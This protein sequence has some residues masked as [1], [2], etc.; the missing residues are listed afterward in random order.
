[1]LTSDITRKWSESLGSTTR[2]LPMIPQVFPA[3]KSFV[4]ATLMSAEKLLVSV[5][6]KRASKCCVCLCSCLRCRTWALATSSN[7][8][9]TKVP[10]F[11][12]SVSSTFEAAVVIL[13]LCVTRLW[14]SKRALVISKNHSASYFQKLSKF[15]HATWRF[16]VLK[17]A[18]F[19]GT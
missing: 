11:D 2:T 13:I 7:W 14:S 9:R 17:F 3:V 6:L 10:R 1:M 8:P 18:N 12:A 15:V 5:V 16:S 4:K 19:L